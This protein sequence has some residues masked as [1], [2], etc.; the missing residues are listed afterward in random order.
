ME[1]GTTTKLL[2][3]DQVA[4]RLNASRRHVYH[5]IESVQLAALSLGGT[6][7]WWRCFFRLDPAPIGT[8]AGAAVR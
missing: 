7:G 1:N 2:R 6:K 4:E 5:L 3:V 8:G